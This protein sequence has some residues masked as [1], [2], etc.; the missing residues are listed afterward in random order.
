MPCW[1][2]QHAVLSVQHAVLDFSACHARLFNTS[3]LC[4]SGR[5]YKR[6][7][8]VIFRMQERCCTVVAADDDGEGDGEGT[9][10]KLISSALAVA[11]SG[12]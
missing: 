3:C 8:P 4:L 10:V 12:L 5:K 2:V 1:S 11:Y 6:V 7:K 9:E